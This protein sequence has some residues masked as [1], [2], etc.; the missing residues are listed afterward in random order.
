MRLIKV[1]ES[2]LKFVGLDST[3]EGYVN[4]RYGSKVEPFNVNTLRVVLP[5]PDQLKQ[6]N[7]KEKIIFHPLA[8]NTLRGESDIIIRLREVINI[9]VNLIIGLVGQSLLNIVASPELHSKLTSEQAELLLVMKDVESKTVV[10]F[11]NLILSNIKNSNNSQFF[12]LYLKKGGKYHSNSFSRVGV[13]SFPYYKDLLDVE[14]DPKSAK[15]KDL[16]PTRSKDRKALIAMFKFMFPNIDDNEGYNYG[17]NSNVAP[18]LDTLLKT[19]ANVAARLNDVVSIYKDY[20]DDY[21]TLVFDSDWMDYFNDLDSLVPDIKRI[22]VQFGNDGKIPITE[23]QNS[24]EQAFYK[25]P[26]Q[27]VQNN[28]P[29]SYNHQQV[30]KPGVVINENGIDLASWSRSN[31]INRPFIPPQANYGNEPPRWAM[32]GNVFGNQQ[33]M[34]NQPQQQNY[35]NQQQPNYFNQQQNNQPEWAPG[36]NKI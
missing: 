26:Q 21:E 9:R 16:K 3:K 15:N 19:T 1:Y 6:F 27:V 11:T 32:N 20:I 23:E 35:F 7:P 17:C 2:I 29:V 24:Q 28:N 8:E 33:T 18:F 14:K 4:A 34:F 30:Q 36:V 10:D 13:V 22:P 5:T 25:Q 12:N 31:Q